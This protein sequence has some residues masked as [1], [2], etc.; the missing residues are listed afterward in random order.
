VSAGRVVIRRLG[1]GKRY[2]AWL[3]W[4]DHLAAPVVIKA[5]RGAH[6]DDGRARTAIMREGALLARLGHPVIVRSFGADL[7]GPRP[8]VVL[9]FLDGPRLSTLIRR[10]GPLSAEQLVPLA[11]EISSALA[12]LHNEQVVHLDV[13]P[14]N[15]IMGAPPR[16][17]DLSLARR[18]ED[19]PKL[20]GPIGTDAYMA[21]EQCREEDLDRIGPA[22]D[23]W[24]L[25]AT[26][27]EAANA[28]RPFR[29]TERREPHPQLS[30]A[31]RDFH[32]RVPAVLRE[33]ISACLRVEPEARPSLDDLMAGFD[34]LAPEAHEVAIRRLRRRLR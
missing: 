29:K 9:E 24:G 8:Y 5:L 22:S 20:R 15:L 4:D 18:L 26:L 25:G 32:P 14:Q 6:A 27:Y 7:D 30:E 13:K 11:L 1:G 23:V 33:L 12:Y 31:P 19:V 28:F 3:G 17:I 21:P 34:E 16:L 2:E 10:Y